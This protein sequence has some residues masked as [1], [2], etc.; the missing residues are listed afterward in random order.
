MLKN[1][2][3]I[4]QDEIAR[5]LIFSEILYHWPQKCMVKKPNIV[6]VMKIEG[7]NLLPW[8][9]HAPKLFNL[10]KLETVSVKKTDKEEN[11]VLGCLYY[12]TFAAVSGE[13]ACSVINAHFVHSQFIQEAPN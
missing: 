11:I 7:K 3:K 12:D 8:T 5:T 1:E 6:K 10:W 13:S 2:K 4:F 9:R